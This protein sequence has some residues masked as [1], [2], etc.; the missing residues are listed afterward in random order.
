M[1]EGYK[2]M[3]TLNKKEAIIIN[4]LQNTLPAY[5]AKGGFFVEM[6]CVPD[7]VQQ[8]VISGDTTAATQSIYKWLTGDR[9]SKSEQVVL[10]TRIGVNKDAPVK[11][12]FFYVADSIITKN[13]VNP[14]KMWLSSQNMPKAI[15]A[16]NAKRRHLNDEEHQ[17]WAKEQQSKGV[18]LHDRLPEGYP[19]HFRIE[20]D[21]SPIAAEAG[22]GAA[23]ALHSDTMD[24][25]NTAHAGSAEPSP[26][27]KRQAIDDYSTEKTGEHRGKRPRKAPSPVSE[28]SSPGD[29]SPAILYMDNVVTAGVTSASALFG[30]AATMADAPA[31]PPELPF[32]PTMDMASHTAAER[33]ASPTF[34]IPRTP[35][36][37]PAEDYLY[38]ILEHRSHSPDWV[39]DL[40]PASS[41][42][43]EVPSR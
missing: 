13:R 14:D 9:H 32:D 36:P 4:A 16:D 15:L 5:R 28:L 25:D 21:S 33:A 34:D 12:G 22:A 27:S 26:G 19:E 39:G 7:K 3:P 29:Y 10:C 24:V 18:T 31:L 37:A 23:S 40:S 1:I 38:R 43:A 11:V 17:K 2:T 41:P 35:S 30:L 6:K 20:K 8:Y 42:R